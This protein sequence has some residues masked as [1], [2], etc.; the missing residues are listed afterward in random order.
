MLLF[1][2]FLA[3]Y[4]YIFWTINP[5]LNP[6]L[7]FVIWSIVVQFERDPYNYT[8]V[9]VLKLEKCLFLAPFWPLIPNFEPMTHLNESK[10]S[11]C[12]FKHCDTISEQLKYLYTSYY[13]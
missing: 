8:Q 7:P 4:S 12:G 6:S 10:P 1:G 2:P 11:T 13:P 5:K 3:P 9:I